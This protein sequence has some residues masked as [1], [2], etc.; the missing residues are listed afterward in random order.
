[1][2]ADASVGDERDGWAVELW[3]VQDEDTVFAQYQPQLYET[4]VDLGEARRKF[5]KIFEDCVS[6]DYSD[7]SE[8][9]DDEPEGTATARSEL[10][11]RKKK[12]MIES[13]NGIDSIEFEGEY[14]STLNEPVW[15]VEAYP[16]T[17]KAVLKWKIIRPSHRLPTKAASK[18]G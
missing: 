5:L 3:T 16:V 9:E 13:W 1:M 2:S 8:T 12:D 6:S 18:L 7:C 10:K 15:K 14:C 4:F 17:L 11:Y